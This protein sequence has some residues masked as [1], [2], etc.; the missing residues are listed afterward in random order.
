MSI[1]PVRLLIADDDVAIRDLLSRGL[2]NEVNVILAKDGSEAVSALDLKPDI[3]LVDEM[4]PGVTGTEVLRVA[5]EKVP[6]APRML[7]TASTD[8]SAAMRAVNHGEIHRFYIKPVRLAEIKSVIR[9]L[10]QKS[11]ADLALRA[12]LRALMAASDAADTTRIRILCDGDIGDLAHAAAT[13]RGFDVKRLSNRTALEEAIGTGTCDVVVVDT[14]VGHDEVAALVQLARTIN[15]ATGIVL[16]DT[17][18]DPSAHVETLTRAFSL[19]VNDCLMPP[20]PDELLLSVRLERAAARPRERSQLRRVTADLVVSNRELA[21]A[22]RRVEDDQ[23]RLLT[24]L[25]RTL[26][27]R[28]PYTAGHT[29]R[30]AGLSVR[31]GEVFGLDAARLEVLRIGAMLH[32]IGKIGIRDDVLYKPGR[33]TPEEFDII[34][35]HTTIGAHILDGIDSL[36]CAVPMVRNHHE[37]IDGTGYPD[38]LLALSLP[39]EV[40]IVSGADVLDAV[41]STRPYHSKR[42]IDEAMNIMRSA[43][44]SQIDG[45]VVDVFERLHREQRLS[46]LL[47]TL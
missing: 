35:T 5:K 28:D 40:R 21:L 46:D 10:A 36:A 7:M 47:Q 25:M 18:D 38:G 26:E 44:G 19:G 34:K 17:N 42:S 45:D 15:T 30:V 29:D 2:K 22:T 43:V 23:V 37:R 24:S 13:R 41:T 4:M 20:F 1:D 39:L 16:V 31:C 11:R 9:E 14:A 33:L 8:P 12:E 3:L 27:A 32:D 6:D